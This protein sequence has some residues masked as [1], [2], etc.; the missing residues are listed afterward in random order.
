MPGGWFPAAFVFVTIDPSLVDFNIHPAKK[1]VRFRTLPDVHRVV[2]DVVRSM[3]DAAPR[4]PASFPQPGSQRSMDLPAAGRPAEGRLPVRRVVTEAPSAAVTA[5]E[6]AS[7]AEPADRIRFLGQVFG[8]FLVFELPGRVLIMDQHAA[9]ERV[10][11][12]RLGRRAPALQEMLFPLSFDAS[13]D[14]SSRLAGA[15]KELEEMGVS[16][17]RSGAGTWEIVSVSEEISNVPEADLVDLLR[18]SGGRQWQHDFRAG[19]AC[20]MAI[21]EG[22]RVDPV[23]AV[24]LCRQ[25]LE[26]PVPRCPHGRPIWHELTEEAL[27]RLVD[28]PLPG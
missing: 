3:L 9:H 27:L 17:R 24:E 23:T 12:E 15:E 19:A 13:E 8:V 5:T 10:L 21:K 20:R 7:A 26:L 11:F 18:S 14:E 2:V 6:S 1:E 4:A 22:D 16:L 25:A 28:R